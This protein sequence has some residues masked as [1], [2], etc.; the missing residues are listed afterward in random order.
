MPFLFTKSFITNSAMRL[1][2]I[3]PWQTNN[4]LIILSP[5]IYNLFTFI[6][7][8]VFKFY[9]TINNLFLSLMCQTKTIDDKY[10]FV[11]AHY[12]EVS[13]D[14]LC[15]FLEISRSSY[16]AWKNRG[17]SAR[18]QHKK[19]LLRILIL[20]HKKYPAAGLDALVHMIKPICPCSRNTLHILMKLHNIHSIRKKAYK[21]TTN[22][23]HL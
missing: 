1:P 19:R 12:S 7:C 11:D 6:L 13:I 15:R 17:V 3:F 14:K 22:A 21:I 23:N 2:Q 10:R 8:Y 4:I 18:K 20:F 9:H 16:Y 5:A